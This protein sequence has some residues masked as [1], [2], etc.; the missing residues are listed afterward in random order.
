[1]GVV[2]EGFD[3]NSQ[4]GSS[5]SSWAVRGGRK[6]CFG[7]D[8]EEYGETVTT[9]DVVGC[10]IVVHSGELF[11]TKNGRNLGTRTV[12]RAVA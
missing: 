11:F 3:C 12:R 1:M 4:L 9:G 7:S 6:F 2:S 8:G 10:G 5:P